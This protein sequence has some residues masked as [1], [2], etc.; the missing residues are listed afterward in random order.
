MKKGGYATGGAVSS[1][2]LAGASG[3]GRG[4]DLWDD[5]V[6]P[7][8]AHQAISRVQR[9]GGEA[10]ASLERWIEGA[11]G[12]AP[13]FAFL[14][15]YEPHAPYEPPEPFRSRYADPYDGEVAAT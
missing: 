8:K 5:D 14:H 10:E 6:V 13:L 11:T 9:P 2:V 12:K 15:V 3:V 1:V 7:T 4:F